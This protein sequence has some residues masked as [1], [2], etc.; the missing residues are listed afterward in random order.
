MAGSVYA[1]AFKLGS[2]TISNNVTI[3]FDDA[4]ADIVSQVVGQAVDVHYAGTRNI[5]GSVNCELVNTGVADFETNFKPTTT[6]ATEIHLFGDTATY[7]EITST[8]GTIL[9]RNA[10]G[11]INGIVTYTLNFALDD[12]TV[13]AAA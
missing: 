2:N 7:V 1:G 13:A 5:T 12:A 3:T 4:A 10:T 8:K 9:S 11:S 6:G